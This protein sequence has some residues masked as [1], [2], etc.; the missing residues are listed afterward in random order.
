MD[1]DNK[2]RKMVMVVMTATQRQVT[3][4]VTIVTVTTAIRDDHL[5]H[6]HPPLSSIW[7]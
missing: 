2:V 5:T 4:M 3:V 1:D 7:H 6:T